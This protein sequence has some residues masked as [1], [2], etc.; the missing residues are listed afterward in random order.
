MECRK[1]S[2]SI[3]NG[4]PNIMFAANNMIKGV[5]WEE[6]QFRN[7][8][9]AGSLNIAFQVGLDGLPDLT[10]LQNQFAENTDYINIYYSDEIIQ[11]DNGAYKH[12][13][14]NFDTYMVV[15]N[16]FLL[17]SITVNTENSEYVHSVKT[18]QKSLWQ[19]YNPVRARD[20]NF[21]IVSSKNEFFDKLDGNWGKCG[22]QRIDT[23]K[24][25]LYLKIL[26][27]VNRPSSN[28]FYNGSTNRTINIFANQ[29]I[30]MQLSAVKKPNIT[31][32]SNELMQADT[33]FW[34]LLPDGTKKFI[35][36]GEHIAN[37]IIRRYKNG[38]TSIT[39]GV[40]LDENTPRF[41]VGEITEVYG[42]N[43][44]SIVKTRGGE[45]M[46]FFITSA[47]LKWNG[48]IQQNLEMIEVVD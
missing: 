33:G 13:Y 31:I 41:K 37:D 4:K 11:L 30:Q 47:E 45:V 34:I 32:N 16:N 28:E 26:Y 12:F 20:F 15:E 29:Q 39:C 42:I 48:Q 24:I 21:Y 17:N 5:E 7:K 44:K 40:I 27:R 19:I 8:A 14:V 38:R 25:I 10:F 22:L 6:M 46:K 35:S 2:A 23:K 9:N 43:G 1:I 18:F 36:I 3:L